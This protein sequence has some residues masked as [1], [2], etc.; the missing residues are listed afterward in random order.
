MTFVNI[1]KELKHGNKSVSST[2]NISYQNTEPLP[3]KIFISGYPKRNQF[4]H[5]L[6]TTGFA[7]IFY[8]A[9][10]VFCFIK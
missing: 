8:A 4:L 6:I 3:V 7:V 5:V 2:K 1:K 9:I 10:V